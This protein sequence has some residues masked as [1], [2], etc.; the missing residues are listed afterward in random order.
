MCFA[1][2][3]IKATDTHSKYVI[4]IAFPQQQWLRER[5]SMLCYTYVASLVKT[6]ILDTVHVRTRSEFRFGGGWSHGMKPVYQLAAGWGI[7]DSNT[8]GS[9]IFHT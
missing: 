7:R 9:N 3:L 1:C 4:L 5:V 2:W 8:G 6:Y